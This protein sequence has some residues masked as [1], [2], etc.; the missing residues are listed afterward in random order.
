MLETSFVV[1]LVG[2]AEGILFTLLLRATVGIFS[3]V[4]LF[5]QPLLSWLFEVAVILG[6]IGINFGLARIKRI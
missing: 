6:V 3:S 2:L 5:T 1:Q 4:N